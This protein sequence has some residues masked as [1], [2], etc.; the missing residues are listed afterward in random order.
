MPAFWKYLDCKKVI[1]CES[2]IY[3]T[4]YVSLTEKKKSRLKKYLMT[5]PRK[6]TFTCQKNKIYAMVFLKFFSYKT[7]RL[8]PL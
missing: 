5:K 4:N 7:N 2:P 6:M 3:S 8:I 1:H